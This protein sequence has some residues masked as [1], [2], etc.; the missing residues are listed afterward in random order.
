VSHNGSFSQEDDEFVTPEYNHGISG[1]VTNAIDFL[2]AEWNNKAAG[3]VG[4]GS[5]VAG[6]SAAWRGI[7]R[8]SR[9]GCIALA[10]F[11]HAR[12]ASRVGERIT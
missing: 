4:Y 12:I 3:F 7:P 9:K 2:Y 10:S 8:L 5:A 11:A 1:A 6:A